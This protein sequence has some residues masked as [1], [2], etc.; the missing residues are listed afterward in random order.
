MTTTLPSTPQPGGAAPTSPPNKAAW[1]GWEGLGVD[2]GGLPAHIPMPVTRDGQGPAE[3]H[4]ADHTICW[5]GTD[6]PLARALRA[7]HALGASTAAAGG[8]HTPRTNAS[9][10]PKPALVTPTPGSRVLHAQCE[11]DPRYSRSECIGCGDQVSWCD[12]CQISLCSCDASE[13]DHTDD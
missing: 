6:C 10:P 11:H 9:T 7:A 5:C 4:Q 8:P 12:S 3:P 1:N 2:E 13:E